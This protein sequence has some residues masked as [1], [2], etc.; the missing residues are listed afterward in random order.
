MTSITWAGPRCVH[1]L[2]TMYFSPSKPHSG[3]LWYNLQGTGC[4]PNLS[5]FLFCFFGWC[6]SKMQKFG[7]LWTSGHLAKF[8]EGFPL[9]PIKRSKKGMFRIHFQQFPATY[10]HLSTRPTKFTVSNQYCLL[11][12]LQRPSDLQDVQCTRLDSW[13]R[14]EGQVAQYQQ[15]VWVSSNAGTRRRRR[16]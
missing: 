12:I 3:T 15:W 16:R 1:E 7:E 10:F 8:L 14:H 4:L 6:L 2:A 11:Y 13:S 5:P 9:Y